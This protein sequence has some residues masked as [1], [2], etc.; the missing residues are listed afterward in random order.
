MIVF[1]LLFMVG[2]QIGMS[3]WYW[4]VLGVY[5]ILVALRAIVTI[6]RDKEKM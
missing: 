6:T 2:K 5:L 3:L 1:I 4:A